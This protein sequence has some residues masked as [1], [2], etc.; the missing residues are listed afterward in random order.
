MSSDTF[1]IVLGSLFAVIVIVIGSV[2]WKSLTILG[3]VTRAGHRAADR[4]RLDQFQLFERLVE[5]RDVQ[6]H[7]SSKLYHHHA[8]ERM[9]AVN[10]NAATEQS[11]K[12]V[13]NGQ[14]M[15]SIRPPSDVLGATHE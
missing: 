12:P 8:T 5:R 11:E 7:D 2:T 9:N 14:P 3:S 15:V 6:Q 13:T 4:E 10:R 1:T